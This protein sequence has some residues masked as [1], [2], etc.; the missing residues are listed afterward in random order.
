MLN[1][2]CQRVDEERA[3]RAGVGCWVM[4][5]G[6]GSIFRPSSPAAACFSASAL[7]ERSLTVKRR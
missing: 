7:D 4:V 5:R 1:L 3:S 6:K 2:G